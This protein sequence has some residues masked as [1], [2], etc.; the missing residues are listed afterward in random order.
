[1][2]SRSSNSTTHI[3]KHTMYWVN[4]GSFEQFIYFLF[5]LH[6]LVWFVS[7]N[8]IELWNT[9]WPNCAIYYYLHTTK[10]YTRV[11]FNSASRGLIKC[12]WQRVFSF[13]TRIL[14]RPYQNSG[15]SISHTGVGSFHIFGKRYQ[16]KL[17][18]VCN[19]WPKLCLCLNA[20][21]EIQIFKVI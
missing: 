18:T 2:Y 9:F 3:A 12:L 6:R 4:A 16:N 8:N 13:F 20:Q 15:F 11:F 21:P 19:Q 5:F 17:K 1:M 10:M 14:P 7:L